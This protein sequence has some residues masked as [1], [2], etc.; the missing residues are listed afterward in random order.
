MPLVDCPSTPAF[1]TS[2]L[3]L[4]FFKFSFKKPVI[5][6]CGGVYLWSITLPPRIIAS[7]SEGSMSS[8]LKPW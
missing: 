4:F 5:V 8:A 2:K 1:T 3:R 6:Y 7:I